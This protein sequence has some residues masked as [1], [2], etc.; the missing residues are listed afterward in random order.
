[1]LR[2]RCRLALAAR[3]RS[4][5]RRLILKFILKRHARGILFECVGGSKQA[6]SIPPAQGEHKDE[7][8][9]R[10]RDR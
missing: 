2:R 4:G 6:R 8:A 5:G 3:D 7:Q 10:N 9:E 1:M